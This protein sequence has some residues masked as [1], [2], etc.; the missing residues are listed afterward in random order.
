MFNNQFLKVISN[1]VLYY[2]LLML[3]ASLSTLY[4]TL[5]STSVLIYFSVPSH[6]MYKVFFYRRSIIGH[7]EAATCRHIETL[8]L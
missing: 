2:I 1:F 3:S 4:V 7:F 8:S 5:C 6:Y